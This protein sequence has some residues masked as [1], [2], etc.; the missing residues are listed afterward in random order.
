MEDGWV[1]FLV[2]ID[3][4]EL[5]LQAGDLADPGVIPPNLPDLPELNTR[6]Q[7]AHIRLGGMMWLVWHAPVGRWNTV[8]G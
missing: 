3:A 6:T 5:A 1:A 7:V 4:T 2:P 8:R